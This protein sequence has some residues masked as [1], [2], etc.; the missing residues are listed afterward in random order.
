[1][2]HF[3]LASWLL[4]LT[5][6]CTAL[7]CSDHREGTAPR[8]R[9]KTISYSDAQIKPFGDAQFTLSYN[10]EN[11]LSGFTIDKETNPAYQPMVNYASGRISYVTSRISRLIFSGL[12]YYYDS[13][14]RL[15]RLVMNLQATDGGN[16][17]SYDFVYDGTNT[18]PSSRIATSYTGT[19]G[20]EVSTGTRT[21]SYTFAGGNATSINGTSYTYD[22]T[23][24]PYRGL[25]GFNE[26]LSLTP[27]FYLG[28]PADYLNRPYKI[29][30]RFS[31]SS[32]KVFN[33][34]NRTTDAQLTYNSDNLVTKIVYKDGNIEEFTYETY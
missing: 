34:N 27:D 10:N 33:Q 26:Y 11:Q 6:L 5:T 17:I 3:S 7:T 14:N 8:F 9:V 23:P 28:A 30:E 21:E 13:Q 25:F 19:N 18:V 1:M 24:N 22:T 29:S 32:V 15:V 12:R 2:K 4:L 16:R 31:G 20:N